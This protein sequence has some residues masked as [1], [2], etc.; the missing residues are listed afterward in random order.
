MGYVAELRALVGHRPLLVVAAGVLV[1]DAGGRVLLHR[2]RDT[3]RWGI[4]GGALEPGETLEAA[5]RRE[6]REETGVQAGTPQAHAALVPRLAEVAAC[7]RGLGRLS[8]FRPLAR[9]EV[10]DPAY[11]HCTWHCYDSVAGGSG[12][13]HSF[14]VTRN[15]RVAA[16]ELEP[17]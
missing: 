9:E 13:I 1:F 12:W 7:Y 16:L 11:G 10:D 5:A 15:G 14:A 2:H 6:L 3:G 4:P 8:S 17:A